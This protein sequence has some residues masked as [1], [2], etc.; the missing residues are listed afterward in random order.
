MIDRLKS[1]IT[2]VQTHIY[3]IVETQEKS[4]TMRLVDSFEEQDL[5]E[6]LIESSKPNALHTKRHYLLTTPFR[7]PPLKHGSRFGGQFEPSLF[8]G[9]HTLHT[10]L[11]ET[12]YYSFLFIQDMDT[13][14]AHPINNHKTSFKALIKCAKYI[15]LSCIDDET[16]QTKLTHK[17]SYDYPQQLG[18]SL[19]K[20]GIQAFSY[21]SAR[22]PNAGL[23]MGIFELSAI[24]GVPKEIMQWEIKQTPSEIMF[25]C[26]SKPQYNQVIH[27]KS[28]LVDERVPTASS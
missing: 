21:T 28:F 1:H 24:E 22:D 9:A 16:L 3:R 14:F 5:L 13:P 15:D 6:S 4:A 26:V 20:K 2:P 11:H 19:R 10:M 25:S 27:I 23:N 8:Y 17:S 18:L 7:Y 12:A